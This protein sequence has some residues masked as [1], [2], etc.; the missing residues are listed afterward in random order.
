MKA[1]EIRYRP[2]TP[3]AERL[4][5][6]LE[7]PDDLRTLDAIHAEIKARTGAE[8]SSVHIDRIR[9]LEI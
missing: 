2:G 9:A 1:I 8:C 6:E 5:A 4:P 3:G 7:L